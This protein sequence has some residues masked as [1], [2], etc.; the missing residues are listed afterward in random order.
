MVWH[1]GVIISRIREDL[2]GSDGT[3]NDGEPNRV[4]TLATTSDVDI[5][6]VFLDGLLL[7]EILEYTKNDIAKTITILLPVWDD[8][9]IAIFFKTQGD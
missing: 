7:T 9:P 2:L 8:Q 4:Y 5:S 1:G 3:G 6:E